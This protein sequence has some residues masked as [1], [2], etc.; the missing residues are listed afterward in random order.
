MEWFWEQCIVQRLDFATLRDGCRFRYRDYACSI[1]RRC[2]HWE[3]F[4]V[5]HGD[6]VEMDIAALD[7]LTVHGGVT[8]FERVKEEEN[9]KRALT[10]IGFHCAHRGDFALDPLSAEH[11]D[12]GSPLWRGQT[13]RTFSYVRDQLRALVD[14]LAA[15]QTSRKSQKE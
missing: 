15:Q 3:G 8:S 9:S 6:V 5:L 7:A 12:P 4:V 11:V 13:F 1:E 2:G 10:R 14:Q